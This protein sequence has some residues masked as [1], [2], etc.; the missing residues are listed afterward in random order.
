[1]LKRLKELNSDNF[2]VKLINKNGLKNEKGWLIMSFKDVKDNW[3]ICNKY[4]YG[5]S[6][7]DDQGNVRDEPL[8]ILCSLKDGKIIGSG[9][10]YEFKIGD[11]V[12]HC[13]L[14]LVRTDHNN[15]S[16]T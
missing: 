4:F 1:M 9:Q 8:Q 12:E 6:C 11:F 16:R 7:L 13:E 10:K 2:K 15:Y 5:K 3:P 14:M